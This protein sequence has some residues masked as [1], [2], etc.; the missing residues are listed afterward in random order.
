VA[1]LQ[2]VGEFL[3]SQGQSLLVLSD[4]LS[5]GDVGGSQLGDG[6]LFEGDL[7]DVLSEGSSQVSFNLSQVSDSSVVDS[8]QQL[9]FFEQEGGQRVDQG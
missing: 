4:S 1:V 6:G 5:G 8:G 7:S 2:Q 9:G 3:L